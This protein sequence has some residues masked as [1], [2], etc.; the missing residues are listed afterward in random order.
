MPVE[1]TPRWT[2][3]DGCRR[4]EREF[5]LPYD[6]HSQDWEYML[7]DA[8]LAGE[9]IERYDVHDPDDDYRFALAAIAIDSADLAMKQ[10]SL[11]DEHLG[12][13]SAILID[14]SELLLYLIHYW[15]VFDAVTDEEYFTISPFFR[16]IWNVVSCDS[17]PVTLPAGY[18]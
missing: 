5:M 2:S 15:C 12:I 6:T 4:V 17:V 7:S 18:G 16:T 8:S 11:S 3:P 9:F 10:G 14:D 1:P 13:L